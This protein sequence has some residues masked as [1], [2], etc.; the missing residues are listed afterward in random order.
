[1]TQRKQPTDASS[2]FVAGTLFACLGVVPSVGQ[3]QGTAQERPEEIVVTSSLIPTPRRQIGTAVSVIEGTDIELRG[4]D[5]LAGVLRTQVGIGVSNSGGPGKSTTLRIRGEEGFRT[6]LIIDGVKAVDPSAP[7]VAPS[8]DSLLT[9]NDLQR[10]EVLRGPQGFMYGADA[11]GVVNVITGR[12]ADEFG[13]QLGLEAGE[14]DT[15]KLSGSLAGGNDRGDFYVSAT[16]LETDGFNAQTSD[17]VLRD[18]DGAENTTLHAKLGWN[19]TENLRLQLVARDIDASTLYDGCFTATFATVHDCVGTTD[20]RTY[21]LSAEHRSG[22]FTNAFGYSNVDIA[23]DNFTQGVSSFATQG[24]IGRFEYTGSYQAADALTL[25]YGVDLQEEE[26]VSGTQEQARDQDGYYVEYQGNFGDSFYF[27]AGA[28]YDDNEDFG[29]HTSGRVTAAYVQDLDGGDS[30]KYRASVG[31]GFRPP[32]LFEISYNQR[33]FG[34]LPAAAATPLQEETSQ[35]YDL[36]IEYTA[37]GGLRLEVTY[38]DQDVEDAIVYTFDSATFA[39][40]YV[41]SPGTSTSDGIEVGVYAPIGQRW[42]FIGNW[43]NNDTKTVEGQPRLRRPENLGNL[44]MEYASANDAFRFIAN[45]RI[46]KDAIDFGG[47]PL[48]D[49]EV[50]DLSAA[51]AFNETFELYG[52]VQ[53]AT[54]E[55]YREVIGF[56]TAGREAYAGVRLRF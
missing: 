17:T 37:A 24:E 14:F 33:P 27:S 44:G 15:R 9:T 46:S 41:Q 2:A 32:S 35:G 10:V 31:T 38:F 18:D 12:G 56:N 13:G 30:L 19:A 52:R 54:D 55:D 51:Y 49:Y 20:Q 39:D 28:R 47:T 11:G 6:L 42:A 7:Q 5:D 22:D 50:L 25:V 23:H 45:Y 3:T 4:Y 53:N 43:T 36:G 8:F 21:K 26:V 29:T 1:M 16:D 34:V 40:G 48:D